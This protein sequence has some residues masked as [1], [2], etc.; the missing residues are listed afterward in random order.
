MKF[1][2]RMLVNALVA[3]ILSRFLIGVSIDSYWTA[4]AF[5]LILAVFNYTV[6]PVLVILTLP[7][8]LFTFGLF[9]FV[10]NALVIWLASGVIS[11]IKIDT[12]WSALL[13]G[14]LLSVISY[15]IYSPSDKKG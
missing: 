6:K 11:G 3:F 15:L 5:S 14:A 2:F 13:F 1:I 4:I 9:L 8:T 10:V 12:F 7:I